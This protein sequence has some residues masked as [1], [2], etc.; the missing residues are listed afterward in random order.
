MKPYRFHPEAEAET[1]AAF[2]HYWV[3]SPTAAFDFDT[4]LRAAYARLSRTPRV[5][6]SFLHGTRRILLERFP[7]SVVF[8][9]LLHEIQIVAVAH[10]KRRPGYWTNRLRQ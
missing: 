6:P 2:E 10:A 5:C 7:F 8:R 4:E 3:D 1:D 9:E